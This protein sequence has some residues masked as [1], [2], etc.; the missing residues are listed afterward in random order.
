MILNLKH[1]PFG[2]EA[3]FEKST[4]LTFAVEKNQLLK[5]IPS[6]LYLDTFQDKWAFIAIAMV[7]TKNLRPKGFPKCL[8]NDFYLIGYRIFV[9]YM[10]KEG[11]SLRGLYILKSETDSLKMK[12]LG[13]LMTQYNYSKID[14]LDEKNSEKRTIQSIKSGINLE[15]N[16]TKKEVSLPID[17]PFSSWKEARQFAGPLPNT[18]FYNERSKEMLIIEG[19]RK[20]WTPQPIHIEQYKFDFLDSLGLENLVLANAFEIE[21][22]EYSW[23]KGRIEKVNL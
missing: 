3:F 6:T 16:L 9:R 22:V 10:T 21:N 15:I 4:V 2:V 20:N 7:Q 23:K 14:I 17:S 18:F 1:H 8:G 5:Y 13:D 19:I 11:K 12:F